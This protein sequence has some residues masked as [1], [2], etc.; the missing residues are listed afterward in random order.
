VPLTDQ[1][2]EVLDVPDTLAAKRNVSPARMFA[3]VGET[4]TVIEGG[5]A[6]C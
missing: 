4:T 2:T 1:V 6:V 5:G 3:L